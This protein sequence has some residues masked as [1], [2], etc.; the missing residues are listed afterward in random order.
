MTWNTQYIHPV[1]KLNWILYI[2]Y[3]FALQRQRLTHRIRTRLRSMRL[4]FG[5]W[6]CC[7]FLQKAACLELGPF[8]FICP[9]VSEFNF[10]IICYLFF[11]CF[12]IMLQRSSYIAGINY[13]A[14]NPSLFLLRQARHL[15]NECAV[16]NSFNSWW[17]SD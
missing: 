3:L 9:S 8:H 4:Q 6:F 10:S 11:F 16:I 1:T 2:L 7:C 13:L 5:C 14:G 17:L 12:I 15:K